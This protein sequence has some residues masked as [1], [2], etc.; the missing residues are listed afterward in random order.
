M[1]V[2]IRIAMRTA[3]ILKEFLLLRDEGKCTNFDDNSKTCQ[4]TTNSNDI[5]GWVGISHWRQT[6]WLLQTRISILVQ[7]LLT[8]FIPQR[9]RGDCKHT[10]VSGAST[11]ICGLRVLRVIILRLR[12]ADMSE[13]YAFCW[14]WPYES[15]VM[16]T[17]S[18]FS[19][20]FSWSFDR[21]VTAHDALRALCRL[22]SQHFTC[23]L[24]WRFRLF[25]CG[26]PP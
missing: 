5:F 6:I 12:S 19:T 13:I 24:F 10:A 22:Q 14:R 20:V 7:E 23:D 9:Y 1:L 21:G 4:R 11:E 18:W 26:P 15:R 16:R 17:W 25:L 3:G 8:E 2:L